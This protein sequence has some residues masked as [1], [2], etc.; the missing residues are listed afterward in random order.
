MTYFYE[1]KIICAT[2]KE[3]FIVDCQSDTMLNVVL[4]FTAAHTQKINNVIPISKDIIASC[5]N[6]IKVWNVNNKICI[7]QTIR[8]KGII[9]SIL[10]LKKKF[11]IAFTTKRKFMLFQCNKL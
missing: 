8:N 11:I 4:S 9:Y 2:S 7:Y 1:D 5:S 6:E 10:F 3:I